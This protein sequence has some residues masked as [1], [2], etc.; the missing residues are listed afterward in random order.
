MP[1]PGAPRP[2]RATID[3]LATW[4]ETELDRAA[5]RRPDPG[6]T[7]VFHRLNR[8]EYKNAIRDLLALDLD[9]AMQLPADDID[10]QGFDNMADV[11]TVSPVLLERYL[12]VAR[13]AARLAVG[14]ATARPRRRDLPRADP[15]HAGRS[16]GRRSALRFPRR[17][18]RPAFVPRRWRVRHPDQAAPQ[19]RELHPRT[20]HASAARGAAQWHA[21]EALRDRRGSARAAGAGQLCR[22]H[23]RR[24]GMGA[25]RAVCRRR[26]DAPFSAP[27][28][29]RKS[30]PSRSFE[31]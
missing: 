15:A 18:C 27:R 3:G 12:S 9:A 22:Q 30:S 20:R 17:P 14:R 8:V 31:I 4:L 28:P 21:V 19:L 2:D 6:R 29:D 26:A 10:E 5:A 16:D 25:V 7:A 1:P 23:L 11:L 13:K 24:S